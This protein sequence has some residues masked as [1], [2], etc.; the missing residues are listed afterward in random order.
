[1]KR[2]IQIHGKVIV[3]FALLIVFFPSFFLRATESRLDAWLGVSGFALILLGLLFRISSRGYKSEYSKGGYA[4]VVGGPYTLVRN[5]MYLGIFTTGTGM[6]FLLFQ[7]WI[8]VVLIV[9]MIVQYVRLILKEEKHLAESFGKEYSVYQKVV[10]RL[11]PRVTGFLKRDPAEYF[12]LR[13]RWV[14]RE[15][16]SIFLVPLASLGLECWENIRLEHR[17]FAISEFIGFLIVITC[18]I[19]LVVFLVRRYENI[20][21]EGKTA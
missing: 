4:L 9:F 6:V 13:L 5:P 20:S 16:T 8:F 12:P 17:L 15:A 18:F 14:K 3:V 21:G 2:R 11:F 1:M 7:W 19:L 10:P